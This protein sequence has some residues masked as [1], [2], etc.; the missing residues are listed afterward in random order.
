MNNLISRHVRILPSIYPGPLRRLFYEVH[1]AVN[2]DE[3]GD[4][5]CGI[6]LHFVR[7]RVSFEDTLGL[8]DHDFNDAVFKVTAIR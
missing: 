8:G 6:N 2:H 4:P 5:V 1:E 3:Y 7:V